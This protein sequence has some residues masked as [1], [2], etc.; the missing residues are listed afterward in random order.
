MATSSITANFRIDDP[1]TASAFV[2]ALVSDSTPRPSLPKVME[3]HFET[4]LAERDFFLKGPYARGA[5][6][7]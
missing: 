1:N 5:M 6:S 2:D 7:K 4:P 3:T